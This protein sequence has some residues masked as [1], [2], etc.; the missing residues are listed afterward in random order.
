M[1]KIS[2]IVLVGLLL[3]GAMLILP[4]FT[5][6]GG[7]PLASLFGGGSGAGSPGTIGPNPGGNPGLVGNAWQ[8]VFGSGPNPLGLPTGNPT[9][10]GGGQFPSTPTVLIPG[11][12]GN[13]G[14]AIGGN[15]GG[16]AVNTGYTPW[17]APLNFLWNITTAPAGALASAV[18]GQPAPAG[19]PIPTPSNPIQS[20][21]TN[22]PPAPQAGTPI[23]GT[24]HTTGDVAGRLGRL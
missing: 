18:T 8:F 14:A 24:I 20:Q 15:I 3:F 9:Q 13:I 21:S 4:L 23:P 11:A 19:N 22:P 5:G 6:G 1:A 12:G 16:L 2:D 7:N 10:P 17:I